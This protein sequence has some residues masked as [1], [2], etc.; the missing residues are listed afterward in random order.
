[1]LEIHEYNYS[2]NLL[3]IFCEKVESRIKELH[4]NRQIVI[5][6]NS[7]DE[8]I[9]SKMRL[10]QI[11]FDIEDDFRDLLQKYKNLFINNKELIE[12]NHLL[13][14]TLRNYE[15]KTLNSE[16][17]QDEYKHNINDLI[18]Q[19]S[20]LKEKNFNNE[21]HISYLEGKFK[22]LDG[23]L[24]RKNNIY[25]NNYANR[26]SSRDR[27]LSGNK[28]RNEKSLNQY[29]INNSNLYRR[30]IN[31]ND[32][33]RRNEF[34]EINDSFNQIKENNFNNNLNEMNDHNNNKNKNDF[35]EGFLKN[36]KNKASNPNLNKTDNTSNINP[37]VN[38][39]YNY[40]NVY[41]NTA[42]ENS[43][44]NNNIDFEVADEFRKLPRSKTIDLEES[45]KVI[46]YLYLIIIK[47]FRLER[48]I[49]IYFLIEK[50]LNK[51]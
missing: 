41:N 14:N 45:E 2:S 43:S 5:G 35:V 33:I 50:N 42:N 23:N 11:F 17:I 10:T 7:I 51:S 22:L 1:M 49:I 44:N 6:I 12:K 4:Y 13:T 25:L 48:N 40:E 8:F 47:I 27:F 29:E 18:S 9:L 16:K 32:N 30:N 34:K 20:I 19:I 31:V 46:K 36:F 15:L 39:N 26:E 37:G 28:Y 24:I 3:N 38:L 21:E